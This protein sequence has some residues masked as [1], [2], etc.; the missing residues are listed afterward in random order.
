MKKENKP[1]LD[2][3]E[4]SEVLPSGATFQYIVLGQVWECMRAGSKDMAVKES[5]YSPDP[6]RIFAANVDRLRALIERDPDLPDAIK[7]EL[8]EIDAKLAECKGCG[9][10]LPKYTHYR[11]GVWEWNLF[12]AAAETFKVICGWLRSVDYYSKVG[13]Y[14]G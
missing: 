12:H 11:Y 14:Q 5:K 9:K 13:R 7:K 4:Q 3:A 10:D 2:F 1:T 8:G 6:R